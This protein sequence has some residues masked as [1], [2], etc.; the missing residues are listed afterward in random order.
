MF[1]RQAVHD[2]HH[3]HYD[4]LTTIITTIKA[5]K[6]TWTAA[7]CILLVR[8]LA[9]KKLLQVGSS[10]RRRGRTGNQLVCRISELKIKIFFVFKTAYKVLGL[11]CHWLPMP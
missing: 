1:W 8:F 6:A 3:H 10:R 5:L 4:Q 9:A 11:L 2:F 7:M